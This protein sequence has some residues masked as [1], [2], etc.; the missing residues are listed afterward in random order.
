MAAREE[1]RDLGARDRTA[2]LRRAGDRP[3]PALV[4]LEAL[5]GAVHLDVDA[6]QLGAAQDRLEPL[7]RRVAAEH[8]RTKLLAAGSIGT[9]ELV[10]VDPVP[11]RMHL[12]R[13]ERKRARVDGRDR[14][15]DLLGG[16]DDGVA[17]PMR[18][19]EDERNPQRPHERRREHGVERDHVRD[20]ADRT[21]A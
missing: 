9:R 20:D 6:R 2:E 7:G 15:T 18:V 19:P 13:G 17:L 16:A 5:V 12:P 8:E 3:E 1:R 14:R 21:R 10:D 4:L 11:D